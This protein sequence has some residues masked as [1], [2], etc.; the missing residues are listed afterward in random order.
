[1]HVKPYLILEFCIATS[2]P[3]VSPPQ[4]HC[5]QDQVL[6]TYVMCKDL[7]L[8]FN[9]T[10]SSQEPEFPVAH[11]QAH[12]P[13][14]IYSSVS[15]TFPCSIPL[16]SFTQCLPCQSHLILCNLAWTSSPRNPSVYSFH[17][18]LNILNI[19]LSLHL[20]YS[21]YI[22]PKIIMLGILSYMYKPQVLAPS[23][24]PSRYFINVYW[25]EHFKTLFPHIK[26]QNTGLYKLWD[27][28]QLW[29]VM[30]QTS[31]YHVRVKSGGNEIQKA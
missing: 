1:M 31:S 29:K 23:L 28:F 26:N 5:I 17:E 25:T 7:C 2:T 6:G 3:S 30:N 16:P 20:K 10:L 19:P 12:T 22:P 8:I 21:N 11:T 14:W 18:H 13:S 24:A 15:H 9:F 4:P 27:F